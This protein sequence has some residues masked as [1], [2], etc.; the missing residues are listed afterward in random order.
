MQRCYTTVN[1]RKEVGR[2]MFDFEEMV[3]L[4]R[5]QPELFEQKRTEMIESL[6]QQAPER[7]HQRLRGLQF[8]VDMERRRARHPMAACIRTYAMMWES[9]S[10]LQVNLQ[11][12]STGQR[13]ERRERPAARVLEFPVKTV[14]NQ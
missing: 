12:L 6:I 10:R 1:R 4:A 11:H 5:H 14:A 13:P 3:E 7:L 8:R 2:R 9:F